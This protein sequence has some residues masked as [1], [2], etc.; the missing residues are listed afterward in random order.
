MH[1]GRGYKLEQ[2]SKVSY[3]SAQAACQSDNV[4]SHLAFPVTQVDF[5]FLQGW[6]TS[7]AGVSVVW[8]G[9]DI[10]VAGTLV[11]ENGRSAEGFAI[12][13]GTYLAPPFAAGEPATAGC[14]LHQ[15]SQ[16]G[17]ATGQL[18]GKSCDLARAYVCEIAEA[19]IVV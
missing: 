10:S 17:V 5:D 6:L 15:I 11:T 8:Y 18:L 16:S 1:N 2:L 19:D 4:N 13:T 9:G 12:D 7:I 3:T 14:T